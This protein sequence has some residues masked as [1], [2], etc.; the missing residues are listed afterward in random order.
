MQRLAVDP[1]P[2]WRERAEDA[3]FAVLDAEGRS[4]W[5]EDAAY[6][7]SAADIDTLGDT[8][9]RLEEICLDW[10]EGVVAAGDYAAFGFSDLACTLIEDSW[11][12]QDKNLLGRLDLAWTGQDAPRLLRYA[13]DAPAGLHEAS[14][15]QAEWLDSHCNHCD[16][17]N[18][19]HEMLVEA[20]K[21]FGLWGH[22]VHFAGPRDDAGPGTGDYLRGTAQQAGLESSMLHLEELRWNGKR[23]TDQS[24][25]P[26]TVLYKLCPWEHLLRD[27]FAANLRLSGM[28]VIEPAWK[29]LLAHDAALPLLRQAY[30]GHENLQPVTARPDF[31]GFTPVLGLWIVA[32]RA[33]GLG[34]SESNAAGGSCFVPHMFE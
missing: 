10:V 19:I 18:G 33:C 28:R 11:Q 20:W 26:V 27:S 7:F 8:A 24:A 34:I 2:D 29:L 16:Q 4:C 22:R 6:C 3:G 13:A 31:D 23:F 14:L 5:R 1:C 17:F 30:P 32:S 12:R 9:Q 21:H 25:R 15:V